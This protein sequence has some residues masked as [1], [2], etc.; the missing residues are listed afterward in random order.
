VI[1]EIVID[2]HPKEEGDAANDELNKFQL[3]I[4]KHVMLF[5]S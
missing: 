4:G 3:V 5:S 2:S 1:E